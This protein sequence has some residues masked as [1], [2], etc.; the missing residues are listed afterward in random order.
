MFGRGGE[1]VLAMRAAGIPVDVVPGVS[2]V[3][4]APELAGIP[5]T[6]RGVASAVSIVSGHAESAFGPVVDSLSPGAATLVVLMGL[7]QRGAIAERLIARGWS[8]STPAAI[9]SAAGQQGAAAWIGT[10]GELGAAV[11]DTRL[12]G[13]IVIGNVVALSSRIGGVIET[14]P[15]VAAPVARLSGEG[16]RG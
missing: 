10:I 14:A 11:V 6:H 2:S 1:E 12:P 13:T 5:V 8:G 15:Q 3:I 16:Q 9:V 7:N 4:A